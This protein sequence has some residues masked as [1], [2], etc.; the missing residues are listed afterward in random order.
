MTRGRT[1]TLMR[2]IVSRTGGFV[3]RRSTWEIDVDSQPDESRWRD[4]I[5]QVPWSDPPPA[6]SGPDRFVYEIS[7]EPH[8]AT[9]PEQQ[10]QGPWRDLVELVRSRAGNAPD[11]R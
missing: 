11:P 6:S 5:E 10:L 8:E 9:V 2:V 1:L 4:L 7:C 3:G